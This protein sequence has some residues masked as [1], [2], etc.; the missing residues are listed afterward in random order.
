MRAKTGT[1]LWQMHLR[2]KNRRPSIAITQH[3]EYLNQ[4]RL[5]QKLRT[6]VEG[7]DVD[8]NLG[9]AFEPV[10]SPVP[11][12]LAV[13]HALRG[14]REPG[15]QAG[16]GSTEGP[17]VTLRDELGRDEEHHDTSTS[18]GHDSSTT[19]LSRAGFAG[20]RHGRPNG[21]ET[22]LVQNGTTAEEDGRND[23]DDLRPHVNHTTDGT[24]RVVQGTDDADG[25]SNSPVADFGAL[26]NEPSNQEVHNVDTETSQGNAETEEGTVGTTDGTDG[27]INSTKQETGPGKSPVVHGEI[28][29]TNTSGE[30]TQKASVQHRD[31]DTEHHGVCTENVFPVLPV[32][33]MVTERIRQESSRNRSNETKKFLETVSNTQKHTN[34]LG[35]E[36]ET[37][38]GEGSTGNG[39]LKGLQHSETQ[40]EH[41]DTLILG[42]VLEQWLEPR[43]PSTR[44]GI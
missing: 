37:L 1:A 18:D 7:E 24:G 2:C 14:P 13:S 15:L 8:T 30:D 39:N 25:D 6:Q 10:S 34:V 32:V 12:G 26:G 16:L 20:S 36:T 21:T 31:E 19:V 4:R 35:A 42:G 33:L 23:E 3:F 29:V 9:G 41:R 17:Q 22:A 44:R 38:D 5:S 43:V 40:Q 27:S 28:G 11:E